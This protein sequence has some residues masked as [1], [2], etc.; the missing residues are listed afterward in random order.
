[1]DFF[2]PASV[3]TRETRANVQTAWQAAGQAASPASESALESA[4]E[5]RGS[6]CAKPA[7]KPANARTFEPLDLTQMI[8]L[9]GGEA[10]VKTLPGSFVSAM[11][12]DLDALPPLLEQADVAG[13]RK[14]HH[15]FAGAVGVLQYPALLAE[16]ETFRRHMNGHTAEQLREEGYALIHTCQAMLAGIEHQAALLA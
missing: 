1:M 15:R 5:G 13:L 6:S 3:A 14:W 11:R 16:L 8:Q 12:D 9:W 2:E 4:S 10:T 7:E